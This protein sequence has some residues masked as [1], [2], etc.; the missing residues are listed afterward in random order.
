MRLEE[1]IV[2]EAGFRFCAEG[3]SKETLTDP[4]AILS[5]IDTT[6]P[7][8]GAEMYLTLVNERPLPGAE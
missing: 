7:R 2:A 4:K 5:A 6:Q 1:S 8:I 3:H